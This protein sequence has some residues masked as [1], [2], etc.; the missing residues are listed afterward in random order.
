MIEATHFPV[1]ISENSLQ[2]GLRL[3]RLAGWNQTIADWQTFLKIGHLVATT[4]KKGTIIATIGLLP[5][6]RTAW[7]SLVL[8]DPDHR[9]QGIASRMMRWAIEFCA[10]HQWIPMLDATDAGARVYKPLGFTGSITLHRCRVSL[11][12]STDPPPARSSRRLT[13]SDLV[14]IQRMEGP[15]P[16]VDRVGLYRHWLDSASVSAWGLYANDEPEA[17]LFLRKGDRL[18]Q[19]GPLFADSPAKAHELLTIVAQTIASPFLMDLTQAGLDCVKPSAAF[20]LSEE[21]SFLRMQRGGPTLH[22]SSRQYA[23]GGP[24]FS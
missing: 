20:S 4:T 21:R 19:V 11:S 16:P 10:Q 14:E 18:P 24:E 2:E 22:Q 8:V 13:T 15:T 6:G 1:H 5:L 23:I 9:G 7:I 17:V 3:S 12:N